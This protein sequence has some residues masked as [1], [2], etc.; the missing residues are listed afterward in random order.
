MFN[1]LQEN[2]RFRFAALLVLGQFLIMLVISLFR[3]GGKDFVAQMYNLFTP[4]A[5]AMAAVAVFWG[6]LSS[7]SK[8]ASRRIWGWMCAGLV[9][10]TIAELLFLYY[11]IQS[12]E[13]IPF[14]SPADFFWVLGSFPLIFAFVIR[15]LSLQ[16]KLTPR[17]IMIMTA[18][19]VFFIVL[20]AI[21]ILPQ[22]VVNA[23]PARW[24]E[25]AINVF[26]ILSDL[27]IFGV[28]L[29]IILTMHSGRL[30]TV[31]GLI[32]WSNI[33]RA[34]ADLLFTYA[35]WNKSV[36]SADTFYNIYV[37]YNIPYISAYFLIALGMLANQI[38]IHEEA[39]D[40]SYL[41]GQ[42]EIAYCLALIFTNSQN[43]IITASNNISDL[44]FGKSSKEL[45]G[46]PLY[47]ALGA[48]PLAVARM[49][50]DCTQKGYISNYPL[51]VRNARL[52]KFEIWM[53]AMRDR[54]TTSL[55]NGLNFLI[56]VKADDVNLPALNAEFR[57]IAQRIQTDTGQVSRENTSLLQEYLSVEVFA[58]YKL[59]NSLAGG[60]AA[61]YM[62][63][64]FNQTAEFNQWNIRINQREI[65]VQGDHDE[66]EL[67]RAFIHLLKIVTGYAVDMTSAQVVA[68]EVKRTERGLEAKIIHAADDFG[69]RGT[70][71]SF[72]NIELDY[73][74]R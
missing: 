5:A 53:T 51:E 67:A 56:R 24:M 17:Q 28:S 27:V 63:D 57:S 14:P 20:S 47:A 55:F 68:E 40:D 21:F 45:S 72:R 74:S 22:I 23:D 65:V 48:D 32:M 15:A 58:L 61:Q 1:L 2:R 62:L 3:I 50:Q 10:W 4:F 6:W 18:W 31:W 7:D 43:N 8:E 26:Y 35:T 54:N 33:I 13:N 34:I 59:V 73:K 42:K 12:N 39:Q 71:L 36:L 38:M 11:A 60:P 70:K 44:T 25:T 46:L 52:G 19:N 30:A 9:L 66:K 64:N 69:L 49:I 41:P 29:W 37:L 16:V